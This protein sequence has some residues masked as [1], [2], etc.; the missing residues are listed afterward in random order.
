MTSLVGIVSGGLIVGATHAGAE[1]FLT[2]NRSSWAY[3]DVR[4]PLKT[5]TT[6]DAPV[7]AWRDEN[8]GYHSSKSYFTFELPKLP[9]VR[10]LEARV[11]AFET[12]ANDCTKQFA[13]ELWA[14]D[15]ADR[16]TWINQPRE[17]VKLPRSA[18]TPPC[19]AR[20]LD[21][22]GTAVFRDA[23]A[24]GRTRVTLAMRMP[25]SK[26]FDVAYGRHYANDVNLFIRYNT[27]PRTPTGLEVVHKPCGD[28][29]FDTVNQF[30]NLSAIVSDPDRDNLTVTFAAWPVD[31]PTHRVELSTNASSDTRVGVDLPAGALVDGVTYEWA[32]RSSDATDSSAWSAPCR[33]TVDRTPPGAEP[34]VSSVDFPENCPFPGCG[35][36]GIPGRFTFT[37]GGVADVVGYQ[38]GATDPGSFVADQLGGQATIDLTPRFAGPT[39]LAVRSIDRAGNPSPTRVYRYYVRNTAPSASCV[40]EHGSLAEPR[41]CTFTPGM[42]G[43]V[44]YR[45]T[46]ENGPAVTVPADANGNAT[47]TVRPVKDL[48]S[49]PFDIT[50]V[51]ADGIEAT[52]HFAVSVFPSTPD[53][54]SDTFPFWDYGGKVG[55]PG[56]F[57]FAPHMY[58]VAQYVYKFDDDPPQTIAADPDGTATITYLPTSPDSHFLTVYS[59]TADGIHSSEASYWFYVNP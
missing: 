51:T 26:Q 10:V 20:F 19:P 49:A 43:V 38:Y 4:E 41:T 1:A 27:P 35:G 31:D 23:I 29:I 25:D 44:A 45:Y 13:T 47:V 50:S 7:G 11:N 9:G 36:V 18:A 3:I 37:A 56:H 17:R 28:P 46:F 22:D 8:G 33:F 48:G 58:G 12:G 57:T 24:A 32:A 15:P 59:Q 42:P 54:T 55:E 52:L 30:P 5:F 53:I 21:W 34:G 39:Q 2:V 6:G 16:P 14:T 40:P